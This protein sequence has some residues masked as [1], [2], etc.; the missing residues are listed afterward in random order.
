MPRLQ[1]FLDQFEFEYEFVSATERY[2]SG[3]LDETLLRM[4]DVY[5]KVMDIILPTLGGERQETYSPFL[6]ICPDQRQGI[7]GSHEGAECQKRHGRL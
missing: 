6:P 1:S 5:D 4:L 3:A 7:A 2:K